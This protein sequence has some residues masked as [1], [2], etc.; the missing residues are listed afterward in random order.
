MSGS[1]LKV[2]ARKLIFENA[3]RIF[4][5]SMLYIALTTL[6]SWLM[7]SLPG[8]INM[9]DINS[10]LAAGEVPSL[11]IIF[12]NFRLIGVFL[13]LLLLLLHPLLDFG[14]LSYCMKMSRSRET[15]YKDLFNGFIFFTKILSIFV[16]TALLTFL[17]GLLLIIPGIVAG[18][19]YRLAYYILFDDPKKGALQCI[20]ESKA[21]MHGRKLDLLTI[22]LSFLGWYALDF[23]VVVL[24]PLPVALPL[25]SI[26]ISPYVGLTRAAFYENQVE[27]IAV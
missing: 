3:P 1:A 2:G 14:F 16:I 26:W 7:F 9:Q 8:N 27:N 21:I 13:A 12:T 18:Y 5:I 25:I 6:L 10:R 4:Y 15:E 19:R 23:L 22:D 11:A 24:I 20:A 17:W